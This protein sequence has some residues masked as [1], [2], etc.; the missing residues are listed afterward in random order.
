MRPS[1]RRRRWDRLVK[2][3]QTSAVQIA[4]ECG[5][6]DRTV[7]RIIDGVIDIS[8]PTAR[9]VAAAVARELGR[10]VAEVFPA[11]SSIRRASRPAVAA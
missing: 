11:T 10:P 5:V 4:T 6:N 9:R 3:R 1:E 8:T 7:G 2:T